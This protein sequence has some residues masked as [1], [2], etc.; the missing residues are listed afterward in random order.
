MR[1]LTLLLAV[2][3]V[4]PVFGQ[5]QPSQII[6]C[7]TFESIQEFRKLHPGAETDQQFES[8]LRQKTVER[9]QSNQRQNASYTVP[10]IF[11]IVHDGE[12][13]GTGSNLSE[14][15]IDSQ[16]AQ[17]NRDYANLSGSA[18]GVAATTDIQFCLAQQRPDG[19]PLAEAGIERINR[20][21]S[22]WIAPPYDGLSS[23]SYV[24]ETIMPQTIWD[25]SRY[26]NVWTLGL[27]GGLLGK[28]TFPTASTLPGLGSG[29]TNTHA[30]VF[31]DYGSV[32]STGNP[33]S[34]S[35]AYNLGRTLSHETG[36]FMGLF[37]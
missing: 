29:E 30:G 7:R 28:S 37:C 19:T 9:L 24:D 18:Y 21:D 32:G 35:I 11:H 13:V 15:I 2:F 31:V 8:W 3:F 12:A 5:Q 23:T 20:N 16:L 27:T 17:L 25:P 10:I 34:G 36:H 22:S 33:G 6:R 1:A 26:F 4:I 14:A